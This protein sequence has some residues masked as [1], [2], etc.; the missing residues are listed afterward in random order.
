MLEVRRVK[1]LLLA[2]LLTFIATQPIPSFG[3]IVEYGSPAELKGVTK[4]FVYTGL[5]L[6]VRNNIVKE[7]TKRLESIEVTNR[8]EEAEV[9]LMFAADSSTFLAGIGTTSNTTSFGTTS[10]TTSTTTPNYQSVITGDGTV[11]RV[12][13]KGRLRLIMQ[14][15]DSRHS[16]FERRPSTNFARKFVEEYQKANRKK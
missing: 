8:P 6:E 13:D 12:L 7:I 10:N 4:I 14:F 11:I 3:Q 15:G 2:I 16:V 1:I 5:E 9:I